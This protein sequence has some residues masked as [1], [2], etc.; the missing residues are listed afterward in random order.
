MVSHYLSFIY[1]LLILSFTN[2]SFKFWIHPW[3]SPKQS[4]HWLFLT[5]RKHS[6]FLDFYIPTFAGPCCLLGSSLV[7]IF[8][9]L[10]SYHTEIE[11]KNNMS[12]MKMFYTWL[13]SNFRGLL[14]FKFFNK[15]APQI[16]NIKIVSFLS[17]YY[18]VHLDR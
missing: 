2:D 4:S 3:H 16:E 18:S 8:F 11:S 7:T 14:Y 5:G 12:P 6:E 15:S 10:S 9:L 1:A 13:H 17:L